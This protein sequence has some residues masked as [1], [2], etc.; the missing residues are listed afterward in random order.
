MLQGNY[1]LSRNTPTTVEKAAALYE[2]ALA[3]DPKDARAWA[4]LAR[5][6]SKQAGYGFGSVQDCT[7]KAKAA[8]QRALEL[9]GNLAQAHE[10]LGRLN[11]SFEFRWD[12][13]G[14]AL[15][16]A[17][18]LAPG[19]SNILSSLAAYETVMGHLDEATRLAR[20]SVELD[21]LNP[22]ALMIQARVA[23]AASRLDETEECCKKVIELSPGY[24]SAHANLGGT[25]LL[26]GR[27]AE[28]LAEIEREAANGYRYCALALIYHASGR[29]QESDEALA[30][31]VREGDQWGIQIALAYAYRGESDPAFEWLER[32]YTLHDSGIQ[33]VRNHPMCANLHS[34]PRWPAFLEKI[35][36]T[37]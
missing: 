27:L 14:E 3:E 17:Q 34:D 16:R 23:M 33:I 19:D 5:A 15:R 35:G 21:P 2:Q 11:L 36:L 25:Y 13:A 29:K 18:S 37:V 1:F 26:Q 7:T 28:A 4:G 8:V 24:T 20:Q 30:A 32:S 22:S 6:R 10:M 12:K 9:D 31:L